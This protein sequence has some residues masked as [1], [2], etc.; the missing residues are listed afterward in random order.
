MIQPTPDPKE[1][2]RQLEQREP[3]SEF[4]LLRRKYSREQLREMIRAERLIFRDR[5]REWT[6]W[7]HYHCVEEARSPNR[8][9]QWEPVFRDPVCTVIGTFVSYH[10][11]LPETLCLCSGHFWH[12]AETHANIGRDK[13][14]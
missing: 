10:T 4:R 8:C 6:N 7:R 9:L 11:T 12:E 2:L 13:Q 5:G 14:W 3:T 1:F